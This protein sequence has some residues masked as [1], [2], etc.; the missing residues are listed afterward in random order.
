MAR[1]SA[2]TIRALYGEAASTSPSPGGGSVCAACGMLGI[3]LILKA[4][5]I[6]Q[7]HRPDPSLQAAEPAMERLAEALEN[8]ADADC[9]A[10]DSFI[11]AAQLPKGTDAERAERTS[12]LEQAAA[13]AAEAAL[14]TLEHAVD[15]IGQAGALEALIAP[16]V[17]AD[18]LAG[19]RLLQA[20]RLNAIDNARGN[21]RSVGSASERERLMARLAELS[22]A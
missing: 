7:R 5:R 19:R 2:L 17:A 6:S 1:I 14:S 22:D 8:D 3:A 20:A 4:L 13:G 11:H 18:L 21:L 15:A 16:V 10:F 9:A 12:R